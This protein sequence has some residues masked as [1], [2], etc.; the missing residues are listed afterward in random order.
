MNECMN[1]WKDE[2]RNEGMND[3]KAERL[4]E[5]LNTWMIQNPNE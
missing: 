1:G 5:G 4:S 2:S 3:C